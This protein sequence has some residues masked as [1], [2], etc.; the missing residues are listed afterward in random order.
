MTGHDRLVIAFYLS[1]S[2]W[3]V[4]SRCLAFCFEMG[5]QGPN[6]FL[7]NCV[8]LT[9]RRY[10]GIQYGGTHASKNICDTKVVVILTVGT[11]CFTFE[12]LFLVIS[13]C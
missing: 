4:C 13:T 5:T 1:V 8:A 7:T 12:Y 10:Y 9:V 2:L 3:L 11:A 6:H